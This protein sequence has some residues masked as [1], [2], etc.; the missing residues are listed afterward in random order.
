MFEYEHKYVILRDDES[1]KRPL[2][3]LEVL[4]EEGWEPVRETPMPSSIGERTSETV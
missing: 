3:E 4:L 1:A 2:A